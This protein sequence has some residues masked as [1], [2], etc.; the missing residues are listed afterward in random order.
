MARLGPWDAAR[1]V[2]V[3]VSGGADSLAL[4]LLAAAWGDATALIVDHGLRP[5]SAGEAAQTQATLAHRA[6]PARILTLTGLT[7]GSGMPA[8][9]RTARYGALAAAAAQAGLVDVLLG[10]H[11][12]DQAETVLMRQRR[13]SG[14]AGLAGMAAVTEGLSV[15]LLRP[16]L[17]V[18]PERLRATLQA[19]GLPWVEDPTNRDTRFTRARLRIEIGGA[20]AP[21]LQLAAV[22]AG[23]R[24][25]ADRA[26]AAALAARAALF[27]E[28]YALLTPGPLDPPVLARLIRTISGQPHAPAPAAVAALAAAMRPATL[29]GVRVMDAGRLGPGWLLVREA[30]AMAPPVPLRAGAIWDGR[31]RA[32]QTRAGATLGALGA[33]A[34][35]F[36]GCG[37][38]SAVLQ[39]LPAVREAGKL[40]SVAF[41]TDVANR[42]RNPDMPQRHSVSPACGA[43]FLA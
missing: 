18:Q 1:R 23:Q 35:D 11:A 28:G 15:R 30:A 2:A 25:A 26:A 37:L 33:A 39:T 34:A 9:A 32:A 13:G 3:A 6:I 5:E 22:H 7:A 41:L 27:P 20:V 4:A 8:R 31:F 16:L 43:P 17:A 12:G 38:P 14:A 36:R 42:G 10:H 29:G 40:A 21:W 24:T 19:A